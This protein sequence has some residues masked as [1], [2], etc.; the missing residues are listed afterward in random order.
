MTA[1]HSKLFF[2]AADYDLIETVD[3]ILLRDKR[4][5]HLRKLFDPYLHPR[6]IKEMGAPK[7]LR[8]AYAMIDLLESLEQESSEGRVRAL[9]VVHD[10]VLH[11]T[12]LN[13]R[14]NAARVMLQIMKEFVRAHGDEQKQLLLA[15][16]FRDAASG[17][18]RLIRGQIS[19]YGLIEMP[20]AW[21]QL[22]FDDH[23]HDANTKGRKSPTHL[24]MDAWIKGIRYLCVIYYN[25]I[26]PEAATELLQAAEIMGIKLRIGVQLSSSFRDKY[27]HLVWIPRGFNLHKD[28]LAFLGEPSVR[29]FMDEGRA[30]SE[31]RKRWVL[32]LLHSFNRTHLASIND[33]YGLSVPP[34]EEHEFLAFV[35]RAQA[36]LVHLAEFIHAVFLPP[37]S[38]RVAALSE[39]Y[40]SADS[41]EREKIRESVASMNSFIPEEIVD[42]YLRPKANPHL[43]DIWTP[44]EDKDAPPSLRLSPR[45]LLGKLQGL[46]CRSYVTL[47]PSNLSPEDVLEVL[48][49]GEG[50][51]THLEIFNLKDWSQGRTEHRESINRIRLVLNDGSVV[52]AK[53][54]VQGMLRT[55]T[56]GGD[57]GR[58]E[59]FRKILYDVQ[60]L[61]S[62]YRYNRL[63]SRLGSDSMGRSRHS[64]GMGL[65]VVP[66][67]TSRSRKTIRR[68]AQRALPV[69]TTACLNVIFAPRTARSRAARIF[70]RFLRPIPLL[71]AH[72]FTH[73]ET[74]KVF[75]NTTHLEEKGNIASLGGL[76]EVIDNQFSVPIGTGP[77]A[78]TGSPGWKCI[79]PSLRNLAKVAL[80]FVP[81]FF[82][83]YLTKDWWLLAYFGAVIWFAI[84]GLRN[85]TQSVVGGGGL[86]RSSLLKWNDLVS[87]SRVSDSLLFTGFSVPLLDYLIKTVLLADM[88]NITTSTNALLLYSAMAL[89]NGIYIS[90]HN[91]F[92]GLPRAAIVGNFFR[93]MLSIP[94]AFAFNA[95]LLKSLCATGMPVEAANTNLQLWAA[96]ISKTASDF[97]AAV[98]EGAAD[99]QKN[100]KLRLLD[101]QEKLKQVDDLYAQ[102]DALYP[103][104]NLITLMETPKEFLRA[105]RDRS[106]DMERRLIINALDLMYFWMYQPRADTA[107]RRFV[108]SISKDERRVLFAVQGV[109]ERKRI[110]SEMLLGGL[111]G[112]HFDRAL[113]FYLSHGERYLQSLRRLASLEDRRIPDEKIA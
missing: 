21:N 24:I 11:D 57:G 52:E 103:E 86:F 78:G 108:R 40:R 100:L 43:P 17:N 101:Y 60:R 14:Y 58:G 22:A 12:T 26:S 113:A 92:R 73:S 37:M 16:D 89:A 104:E 31:H 35:G 75:P 18:P 2:D 98:I 1:R 49:D 64:R 82:T 93:T 55:I 41:V 51:I 50:G 79:N 25:Y 112:R 68:D 23:V 76:P 10:E 8:I 59:K 96:V 36:S 27:V 4:Q 102:I 69:R 61:Q 20:E 46:P 48:Y 39:A 6:G 44:G 80:G 111:V 47:N 7:F 5:Q 15:Q 30:V 88:L 66:T 45:E 19:K 28:F 34:L 9:R 81:A 85:I 72:A 109:L 110:V 84:T 99:R 77:A 54:L 106:S 105:L 38:R 29:R 70:L 95:I 74:W 33:A 67:L 3:K 65:V 42:R 53:R 107:L 56:E 71:N 97:V 32:S 91:T 13:L 87:W 90:G 94:L 63:R 83:F 62:F